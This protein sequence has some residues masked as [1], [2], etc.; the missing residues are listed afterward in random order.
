M[1]QA[2][3]VVL[4]LCGVSFAQ[5]TAH[6]V[7]LS[8]TQGSSSSTVTGFN[9]YR[10]TVS[11]GPY[12]LQN[13]TPQPSCSYTDTNQLVE[14]QQYVYVATEVNKAG[15]SANS[16]EVTALIPFSKASPPTLAAPVVK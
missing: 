7:A 8:C 4:L 16:N 6:S 9:F 11:G 15:E 10:G 2:L 14:G 5:S 1:K 3:V 12:T 13:S